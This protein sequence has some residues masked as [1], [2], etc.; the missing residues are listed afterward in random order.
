MVH[1][2][3][4]PFFHDTNDRPKGGAPWGHEDPYPI[5]QG[6]LKSKVI[7]SCGAAPGLMQRTAARR[8][9]LIVAGT[10]GGGQ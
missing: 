2:A 9:P 1:P 10:G 7:A 5:P 8:P 6:S 3:A 4:D